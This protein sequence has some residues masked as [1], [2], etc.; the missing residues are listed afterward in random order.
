MTHRERCEIVSHVYMKNK[1]WYNIIALPVCLIGAALSL[2]IVFGLIEHAG[3]KTENFIPEETVSASGKSGGELYY[4]NTWYLPKESLETLLILGIDKRLDGSENREAS[5]QVDFLSLLLIEE[6]EERFRI[7]HLNRDTITDI[8]QTDLAGIEYGTF[9]GQLALA[10]AYGSHDGSRCRN[11]VR[12]VENLLYNIEID[13]YMSLT[14][15]A[16][17]IL[18]DSIGGVTLPLPDDFEGIGNRNE[19]V[20]LSGEQ[21]LHYVR[22]RSGLE[23]SS[24]LHR[25]ER[26]RQY[27]GAL[28]EKFAVSSAER[29]E[30]IIDTLFRVNE[31]MVSDCTIEQLSVLAEQLRGYTFDGILTLAGEAVQ[32]TEYMEFHVDETAARQTV[33]E[34][35][36]EPVEEN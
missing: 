20:T 14:M 12:A 26:Q 27:I 19:V 2:V 36:Y 3:S 22:A 35:F 24:N 32:G 8:P 7:L 18:N 29:E 25:M 23:D 31:Y 11:T 1:S 16:V 6:D 34:L 13:H 15:D 33:A 5:E 4:N 21:A 28:F 30:D 17:A 9:R 10:H